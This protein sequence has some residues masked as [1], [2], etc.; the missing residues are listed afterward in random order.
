MRQSWAKPA[1]RALSRGAFVEAMANKKVGTHHEQDRAFARF[2]SDMEARREALRILREG[3]GTQ[4]SN[5]TFP[6]F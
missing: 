5:P 4:D 1:V 3:R 2:M 6:L